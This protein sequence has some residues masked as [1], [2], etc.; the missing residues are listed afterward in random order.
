MSRDGP[1]TTGSIYPKIRGLLEGWHFNVSFFCFHN[2]MF[3]NFLKNNVSL[4]LSNFRFINIKSARTITSAFKSS[5]K[6]LL[7]QWSQVSKHPE[8]KPQVDAWFLRFKVSTNLNFFYHVNSNTLLK[9]L[10]ITLQLDNIKIKII[11]FIPNIK[12][13]LLFTYR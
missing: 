6:I 1:F 8:W 7:F 12:I 10:R 9:L 2:D 11:V 13:Y 3:N 4:N 5:M